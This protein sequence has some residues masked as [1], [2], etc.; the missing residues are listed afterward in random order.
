MAEPEPFEPIESVLIRRCQQNSEA[1]RPR[2]HD[3]D[4]VPGLHPRSGRHIRS[5]SVKCRSHYQRFFIA[6]SREVVETPVGLGDAY[7]LG[8]HRWCSQNPTAV[9]AMGIHAAFAEVAHEASRDARDDDLVSHVKFGDAGPDLLDDTNALVA[10]DASVDYRGEIS[11]ENV[12]I[13]TTNR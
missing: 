10:E 5:L 2:A 7:V 12:K 11:L 8:C 4:S 9:P 3:G 1:D 13:S 6:A